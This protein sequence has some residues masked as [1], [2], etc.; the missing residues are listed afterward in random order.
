MAMA[1]LWQP[2]M[3]LSILRTN[4]NGT[5]NKRNVHHHVNLEKSKEKCESSQSFKINI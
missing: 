4:Y 5:M 3:R 1:V 2:K